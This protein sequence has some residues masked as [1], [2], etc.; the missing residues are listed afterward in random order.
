MDAR[1]RVESG[2]ETVAV[3]DHKRDWR[4]TYVTGLHS[5]RRLPV[6]TL[7]L[8]YLFCTITYMRQ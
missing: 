3:V 2:Q 6:R 4:V 7:L 5:H 8:I 1:G